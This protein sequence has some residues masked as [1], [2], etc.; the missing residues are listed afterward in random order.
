[1]AR[2]FD[3]AVPEYLIYSTAIVT[4]YPFALSGWFN[5]DDDANNGTIISFSDQAANNDTWVLFAA[6]TVGGDPLRFRSQTVGGSVDADTS[7]GF[8]AGTWHLATVIALSATERHVY[9]DGGSKGTNTTDSTPAG[10][11]NTAIGVRRRTNILTTFSG[12]IG[13]VAIWDLTNWG[14]SD[15]ARELAFEAA[16][17][18]LVKGYSPLFYPLGLLAYWP[19]VRGLNDRIN[20]QNMTIG[21]GTTVAA[22]PRIIYPSK[23]WVPH[24]AAVAPVGAAGIMTTNT[25]YW[26]PTF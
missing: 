1:M 24:K 10:L 23:I 9:I 25:G 13:E 26:G 21:D 6:G 22:H 4:A 16:Q 11:D 19:L 2:L 14:G 8:T 17:L 20:G 3:D 12:L 5:T 15:A 7:S 18:S